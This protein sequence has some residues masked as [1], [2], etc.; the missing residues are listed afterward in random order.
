MSVAG[1]GRSMSAQFGSCE[2]TY[3]KVLRGVLTE[4][5][6]FVLQ[7][8]KDWRPPRPLCLTTLLHC[9]RRPQDQI[10]TE[11]LH[12]LVFYEITEQGESTDLATSRPTRQ[13]LSKSEKPDSHPGG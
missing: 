2:F 11:G 8:E 5:Y 1:S 4:K 10:K 13:T 9:Y 12:K 7:C 6:D 3:G